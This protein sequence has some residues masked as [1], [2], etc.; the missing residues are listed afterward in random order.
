MLEA[1]GAG[2]ALMAAGLA[3]LARAAGN[4]T[5]AILIGRVLPRT[6]AAFAGMALQRAEGADVCIAHVNA[7]G[8][9]GGRRI[10]VR[11]RDDGYNAQQ[12]ARE[13]QQLIEHDKVFAV[14]GAFGTPTV[15]AVLQA[16]EKAG[17]PLVG[18]ASIADDARQPSRKWVF[19]VRISAFAEA[20]ATVRHQVT[21]GA[22]RFLVLASKEA[23]GPSGAAAY[24]DAVRKAGIAVQEVAFSVS[25]PAR[26]V[27]DQILQARPDVMLAAVLPKPFA[28]VAREYKAAG[29][30]A[31]T[32]GLSV[33]RI[34]D[35]RA[36]LGPL[37]AGIAL[38]QP[39]PFPLSRTSPLASDYRK[40][41]SRHAPRAE[42]SYHGL[43]GFL[44]ARILVEGL[45]Q[46][47]P[48]ASR[49]QL[50]GALEALRNSDFG[51]VMVRYGSG[52]RTGS[53][54][55]ELIMLGANGAVVR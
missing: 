19:P 4:D 2:A 5:E 13:V 9:V 26:Q 45:K 46:A 55:S 6:S 42:P 14:L 47:G 11:D 8:G 10:A 54:F 30:G 48:R 33:I 1:M 24:R 22:K 23:Y 16:V 52:D 37:A 18:A 53:M 51:G 12:A 25:D 21:L 15:P 17:V 41:L 43:E 27:A 7:T 38:S 40:L 29:G 35:L 50:V 34:E 20:E 28:A 49:E 3:P 31:R 44:E 32:V 39:V 36:E